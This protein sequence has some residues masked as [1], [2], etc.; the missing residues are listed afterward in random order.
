MIEDL[1][2]AQEQAQQLKLASMGRLSASIA[3]EIRNPLGAIRHANAL[4]GEQLEQPGQARL[5]RII[6]D[7]TVRIDRVVTDVLSVARRERPNDELIDLAAFL[8]AFLD[9]FVAQSGAARRQVAIVI[10]SGE[11]LRFDANHLRRVLVNLVGNALRYASG[12]DGAVQI[13]WQESGPDRLE[14]RVSDDGPGLP[15]EMQ[16]H[17]FEPFFTTEARGTGLGLF[18]SRE[19]CAANGASIRYEPP[20]AAGRGAFVVEL[21]K[22]GIG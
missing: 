20:G 4:L 19:L 16:Q 1:R 9:E 12:G 5:S 18:L 2:K 14:L 8:P 17:A 22:H 10:E 21:A 7:N 6:E 3:H 11:P 15:F 13:G